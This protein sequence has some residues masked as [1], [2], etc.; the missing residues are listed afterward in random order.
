MAQNWP[1]SKGYSLCKMVSLVPK[2][3]GKRLYDYIRVV[4]QHGTG[5]VVLVMRK[6]NKQEKCHTAVFFHLRS[7]FEVLLLRLQFML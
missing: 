4:L 1:Q 3:C 7:E 5:Y 2:R 6:N